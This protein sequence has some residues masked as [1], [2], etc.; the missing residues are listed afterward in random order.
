MVATNVDD[1]LA[2][3]LL[4]FMSTA[5]VVS[6]GEVRA[7]MPTPFYLVVALLHKAG[8]SLYLL[9]CSIACTNPNVPSLLLIGVVSSKP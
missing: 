7:H 9:C 4:I 3:Y 6:Q 2:L 5:T 8:G 1:K